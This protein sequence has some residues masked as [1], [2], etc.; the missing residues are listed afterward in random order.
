MLVGSELGRVGCLEC[1]TCSGMPSDMD[2]MR[3]HLDVHRSLALKPFWLAKIMKGEKS[4]EI[5]GKQHNFVGERIFL[6]E[7]GSG[8]IK[9][10][11]VLEAARELTEDEKVQNAEKEP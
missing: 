3:H 10:T 4:L 5:R 7:T 2:P 1:I 9:A 11:A 6:H 8:L